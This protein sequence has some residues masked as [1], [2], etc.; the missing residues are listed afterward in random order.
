VDA[1]PADMHDEFSAAWY[2]VRQRSQV[3]SFW[4]RASSAGCR[5]CP[6]MQRLGGWWSYSSSWTG[7]NGPR[8][9]TPEALKQIYTSRRH[10]SRCD[11]DTP[12][13]KVVRLS[14]DNMLRPVR[15]SPATLP[16]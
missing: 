4:R 14:G 3:E 12:G 10:E 1:Y 2:D 9:M 8:K 7:D 5:T 11:I 6:R 16:A 13:L 15:P